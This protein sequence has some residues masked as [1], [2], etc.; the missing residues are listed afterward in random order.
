MKGGASLETILGW[1]KY[2]VE[3]KGMSIEDAIADIERRLNG[4]LPESIVTLIKSDIADSQELNCS[5]SWQHTKNQP[6]S[7]CLKTGRE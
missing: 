1:V 4:K 5:P 2:G 7:R 6:R 3:T